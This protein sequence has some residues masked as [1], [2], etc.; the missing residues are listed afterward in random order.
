MD[1]DTFSFTKATTKNLSRNFAQKLPRSWY[2]RMAERKKGSSLVLGP[3]GTALKVTSALVM[4]D[5]SGRVHLLC[6][7]RYVKKCI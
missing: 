7:D 1:Y 4:V 5:E 2:I 6:P 3:D